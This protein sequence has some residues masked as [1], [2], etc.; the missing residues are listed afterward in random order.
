MSDPTDSREAPCPTNTHVTPLVVRHAASTASPPPTDTPSH[1]G[2]YGPVPRIANGQ[3]NVGG[4]SIDLTARAMSLHNRNR[5]GA[6][7]YLATH[8]ALAKEFYS[9]S[10]A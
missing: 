8:Q 7:R 10:D 5:A 2:P 6:M 9:W 4:R 3:S 1:A